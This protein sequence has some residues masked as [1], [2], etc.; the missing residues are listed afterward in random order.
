[1]TA[2]LNCRSFEHLEALLNDVGHAREAFLALAAHAPVPVLRSVVDGGAGDRIIEA[3]R[4]AASLVT[5]EG[6]AALEILE[7]LEAHKFYV[8]WSWDDAPEFPVFGLPGSGWDLEKLRAD[9]AI[10]RFLF[11][12][13][14]NPSF[15]W[16]DELADMHGWGKESNNYLRMA[17]QHGFVT[18]YG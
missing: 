16:F 17:G 13:T 3:R 4:G 2:V 1:M 5:L 15:H 14:K 9:P 12:G 18:G 7:D 6:D 10:A 8:S 11:V